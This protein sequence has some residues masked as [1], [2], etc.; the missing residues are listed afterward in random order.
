MGRQPPELGVNQP[1]APHHVLDVFVGAVPQPDMFLNRVAARGQDD[2][3]VRVPASPIVRTPPESVVIGRRVFRDVRF[4]CDA[5]AFEE[6]HL[7]RRVVTGGIA[8]VG[9]V[10]PGEVIRDADRDFLP[11][12]MSLRTRGCQTPFSPSPSGTVVI[13]IGELPHE[14][15][16]ANARSARRSPRAS[17]FH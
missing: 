5:R 12:A 8:V 3:P 14:R 9:I 2:H 17:L 4:E 16:L 15:A 6:D 13:E 1:E 11:S 7:V 10:D